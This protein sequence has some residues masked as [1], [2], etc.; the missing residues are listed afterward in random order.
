M[1]GLQSP[2]TGNFQ[3][4]YRTGPHNFVH[5]NNATYTLKQIRIKYSVQCLDLDRMPLVNNNV[6]LEFARKDFNGCQVLH[7]HE[8]QWLQKYVYKKTFAIKE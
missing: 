2:S 5:V 1:S 3:N 4:Y 7:Q 8:W 6:Y